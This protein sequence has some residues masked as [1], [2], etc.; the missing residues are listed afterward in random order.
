MM[1]YIYDKI[2]TWIKHIQR[3]G[4]IRE[5]QIWKDINIKRYIHKVDIFI[6]KIYILKIIFKEKIYTEK[7]KHTEEHIYI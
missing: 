2:Y 1:R 7:N 3:Q 6:E 5:K 4:Y